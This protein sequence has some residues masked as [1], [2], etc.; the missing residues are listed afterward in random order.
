MKPWPYLEKVVS[1]LEELQSS[2]IGLLIGADCPLALEPREV[3][4][5]QG[6]GPYAY[7]TLLGWCV[8]GP[9][10]RTTNVQNINCHR[11][12]VVNTDKRKLSKHHFNIGNQVEDTKIKEMFQEI[13]NTDF[14]VTR[15]PSEL[16]ALSPNM[17]SYSV[18]DR[19]FVELMNKEVKLEDKQYTV[20]L[21]FRD[22]DVKMPCNRQ[23]AVKR[24]VSLK[25]K[26]QKDPEFF[27]QYKS[28]MKELL[29]KGYAEKIKPSELDLEGGW[30]LPHHGVKHPCKPGKG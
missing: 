4:C 21:P 6:N 17:Q 30:Y 13:Y 3:I 11:I 7:K 10:Y 27:E 12:A 28:F 9:V 5:S 15:L 23:I 14:K 16:D 1:E 18:E 22:K 24:T 8:V 2:D 20:P 26:F 19:K 29:K 25:R